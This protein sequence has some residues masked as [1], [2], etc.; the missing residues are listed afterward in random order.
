MAVPLLLIALDQ[1]GTIKREEF[2]ASPVPS[3]VVPVLVRE[4]GRLRA[5]L[6]T[7]AAVIVVIQG[8]NHL[9]V[10][11]DE[12]RNAFASTSHAFL[13]LFALVTARSAVLFRRVQVHAVFPATLLEV[14]AGSLLAGFLRACAID[15]SRI[16][17]ALLA[18]TTAVVLVLRR[19]DTIVSAFERQRPGAHT[20]VLLVV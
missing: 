11:L 8:V 12:G 18:T 4:T 20:L 17:T 15:T 6:I 2:V 1:L 7:T 5:V 9:P 14:A 10:T 3:L 13:A 19:V 16:I